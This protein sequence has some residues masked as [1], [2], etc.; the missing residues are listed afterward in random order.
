M[1]KENDRVNHPAH[2]NQGGVECIEAIKAS[3]AGLSGYEGFLVGN[4]IK[5]IWRFKH[6]NGVEDLQKAKW[7]LD[8]LEK[9]ET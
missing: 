3:V 7:Y 4:A 1:T 6:K 5:Y 8:K 9:E 2:Y